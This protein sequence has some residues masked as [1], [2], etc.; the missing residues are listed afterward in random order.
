MRTAGGEAGAGRMEALEEEA[1][2]PF[3][4]WM[5]TRT[6]KMIKLTPSQVVFF[7]LPSLTIQTSTSQTRGAPTQMLSPPKESEPILP[8]SLVVGSITWKIESLVGAAHQNE[9]DPQVERV[10][11]SVI[12]SVIHTE[13]QP[14]L[15][16]MRSW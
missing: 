15:V 7:W 1:E 9:I 8:A 5:T 14:W 13:W 16:L 12:I 2:H 10:Q 4:V 11:W 3:V 6:S